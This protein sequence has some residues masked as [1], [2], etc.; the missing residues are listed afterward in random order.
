MKNIKYIL[1]ILISLFIGSC[2]D[3]VEKTNT[4]SNEIKVEKFLKIIPSAYSRVGTSKIVFIDKDSKEYEADLS[5][6]KRKE[7]MNNQTY[8]FHYIT[9]EIKEKQIVAPLHIISFD[10]KGMEI[11]YIYN[12]TEGLSSNPFETAIEL[13]FNR[14]LLTKPDLKEMDLF[15]KKFTNVFIHEDS[16]KFKHAFTLKEGI[17][18]LEDRFKN[19]YVFDRF[20]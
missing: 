15:N 16:Q 14:N 1:F 7:S 3:S 11:A 4:S 10:D 6:T 17:I 9:L 12:A 8:E 20:K 13:Q 19:K 5:V 18:V 2:E